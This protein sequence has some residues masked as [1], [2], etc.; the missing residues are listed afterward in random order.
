[1]KKNG[2]LLLHLLILLPIV[3]ILSLIIAALGLPSTGVI[4]FLAGIIG[5]ITVSRNA[6]RDNHGLYTQI[7]LS[8]RLLSNIGIG[9]ILSAITYSI[10]YL[11]NETTAIVLGLI[12]GFAA[13]FGIYN[14]EKKDKSTIQVIKGSEIYETLGEKEKIEFELRANKHLDLLNFYL[15]EESLLDDEQKNKVINVYNKK[16][17]DVLNKFE[18][19]Q[20]KILS[21]SKDLPNL[22]EGAK[23]YISDKNFHSEYNYGDVGSISKEDSDDAKRKLTFFMLYTLFTKDFNSVISTYEGIQNKQPIL[24]EYMTN[25]DNK[26]FDMAHLEI[27]SAIHIDDTQKVDKIIS[28]YDKLAKREK[29][30]EDIKA[31]REKVAKKD[32]NKKVEYNNIEDLWITLPEN[33]RLLFL[34]LTGNKY[35]YQMDGEFSPE[36][37]EKFDN[38]IDVETSD[39]DYTNEEVH[40]LIKHLERLIEKD[41]DSSL[42]PEAKAYRSIAMMAKYIETTFGFSLELN[43]K[44]Y[45]SLLRAMWFENEFNETSRLVAVKIGTDLLSIPKTKVLAKIIIYS[46][47]FESVKKR[48]IDPYEILEIAKDATDREIKKKYRELAKKYH[49]DKVDSNDEEKIKENTEKMA[50]INKAKDMLLNKKGK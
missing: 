19:I 13:F 33:E 7:K 34:I 50:L 16:E 9:V 22:T 38:Q 21:L 44:I 6:I 30:S 36:E 3:M 1:M 10:G 47:I 35:I 24:W 32:K 23:N 48:D 25:S 40:R 49:P 17:D 18:G 31:K 27:I 5:S 11:F 8:T 46:M 45:D 15:S 4:L 14:D 43:E 28:S 20:K 41:I 37:Q 39:M 26:S 29:K 12:G 2:K 42:L